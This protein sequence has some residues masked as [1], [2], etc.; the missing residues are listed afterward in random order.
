MAAVTSAFGVNVLQLLQLGV[1]AGAPDESAEERVR[2]PALAHAAI[3]AKTTDIN[4]CF[5]DPTSHREGTMLL[6]W[7]PVDHTLHRPLPEVTALRENGRHRS[8]TGA[9]GAPVGDRMQ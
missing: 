7:T 4:R 9:G 2:G 5:T 8:R 3:R 6:R 1:D